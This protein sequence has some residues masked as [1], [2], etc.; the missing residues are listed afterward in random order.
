[1]LNKFLKTLEKLLAVT[2]V[3]EQ[4]GDSGR[5]RLRKHVPFVFLQNK[6]LG[7]RARVG[8]ITKDDLDLRVLKKIQG[9]SSVFSLM[10]K[11]FFQLVFFSYSPSSSS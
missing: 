3:I 2:G 11:L 7:F 4:T 9:S 8:I 10:T 1:M 5:K 6:G